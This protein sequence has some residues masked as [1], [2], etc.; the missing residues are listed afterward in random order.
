MKAS[1][2]IQDRRFINRRSVG[3]TFEI[4][5][6]SYEEIILATPDPWSYTLTKAFKEWAIDKGPY[7][8]SLD[9]SQTR[10]VFARRDSAMMAKLRF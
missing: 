8:V 1:W 3:F 6:G 5:D 2:I 4:P 7:R 9:G 10:I